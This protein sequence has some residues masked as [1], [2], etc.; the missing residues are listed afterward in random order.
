MN[1]IKK[2]ILAIAALS[3]GAFALACEQ[4]DEANKFIG[5]S[6]K[7]VT[8]A[9]SLLDKATKDSDT[10]LSGDID[11]LKDWKARNEAKTKDI[12][13]TYDKSAELFKAASKDYDDAAKLKLSD[14]LKAYIDLKSKQMSKTSEY[15]AAQKGG[16]Q[17]ILNADGPEA[18]EKQMND[19]KT[20]VD[21]LSKEVI[22][23]SEKV[24]KFEEENKDII[25]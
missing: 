6:N 8:E 20:K 12:L 22:D 10:L 23:M 25:K 5:E 15:I 2:T 18:M 24:K 16:I 9:Q 17:A 4:I 7:K 14:K 13:A 1:T 11:D 3:L 21:G 19:F